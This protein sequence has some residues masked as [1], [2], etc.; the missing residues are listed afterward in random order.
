MKYNRISAKKNVI[1]AS[2]CTLAAA[3]LHNRFTNFLMWLWEPLRQHRP[4]PTDRK[5][6]DDVLSKCRLNARDIVWCLLTVV[7]ARC[8]ASAWPMPSCSV[9]ACVC[10]FVTTLI[11]LQRLSKIFSDLKH[12]AIRAASGWQLSFLTSLRPKV[13]SE[14]LVSDQTLIWTQSETSF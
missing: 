3:V 6:D 2:Q 13:W 8:S 1:F 7:A 5:C 11:D 14:T 12:R 9:C 4:R 10:L